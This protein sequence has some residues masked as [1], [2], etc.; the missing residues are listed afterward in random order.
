[1][2]GQIDFQKPGTGIAFTISLSSVSSSLW[3]ISRQ[4]SGFEQIRT[5]SEGR[6]MELKKPY[7]LIISIVNRGHSELVMEAAK[8][9]GA[10]GGTLLHASGLGGKEAEKFLGI[11][12]QPEK[13]VILI[14]TPQEKKAGIMG[15]IVHEAGMHTA[16]KGICFSL[17]VNAALGLEPCLQREL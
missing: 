13:D 9:A 11:T 6:K 8:A 10:T 2:D 17:P 4:N 16:G 1:L 12:I 15:K 3:N 7:E 14:L 5:E